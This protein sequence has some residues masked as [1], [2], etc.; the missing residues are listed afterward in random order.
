[1]D[2][3]EAVSSRRS[4]RAYLDKPVAPDLLR[5]IL[6][7]ALRAPSGGNLQPW[8]IHVLEGVAK[9]NLIRRVIERLPLMQMGES[10]DPQIYP[11]PLP[12]PY[13]ERR[14]VS[15]A[16]LYDALKI[17][18]EDKQS[19]N[20]QGMKNFEF[21]GAP[22]G[23]IFTSP[24][25]MRESQAIDVGILMQTVMLLAKERGLAS[26]PQ[27]SWRMWPDTVRDA[28]GI[29][30]GERVMAG[31]CLGYADPASPLTN[32]AMPRDRLDALATFH[33]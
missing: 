23:L 9:R 17:P 7:S 27:V 19:R 6:M 22:V 30:P 33:G 26:C 20:A 5:G 14:S 21:F 10:S 4:V 18:K 15:G 1:M 3:T 31:M 16:L 25:I 13:K 32:L 8:H 12:S 28:L 29:G 11:E 2:V 24:S